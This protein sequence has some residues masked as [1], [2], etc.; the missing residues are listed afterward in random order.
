MVLIYREE[1]MRKGKCVIYLL[2]CIILGLIG[3]QEGK[4]GTKYP[5]QKKNTMK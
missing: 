4:A 1:T 3:G 2:L 5:V